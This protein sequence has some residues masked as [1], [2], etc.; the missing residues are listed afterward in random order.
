MFCAWCAELLRQCNCIHLFLF[1]MFFSHPGWSYDNTMRH[2]ITL[3]LFFWVLFV[4]A[5]PAPVIPVYDHV[6]PSCWTTLQSQKSDGWN[7]TGFS[8]HDCNFAAFRF[9]QDIG[10]H[11]LFEPYIFTSIRNGLNGS[12]N[13]SS[14]QDSSLNTANI[15]SVATSS[16]ISLP[17]RWSFRS[18][19][20]VIQMRQVYNDPAVPDKRNI[21]R[22]GPR[23]L[24][25]YDVDSFTDIAINGVQNLQKCYSS[26]K[27]P[28]WTIVGQK[29]AIG[30]FVWQTDSPMDEFTG[31]AVPLPPPSEARPDV[32]S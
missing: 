6:E 19:S 4:Q 21:L 11:N 2:L 30:V 23:E 15:S 32:T 25:T 22:K 5:S 13:S 26:Q 3:S 27:V 7:D 8:W 16:L 10:D 17:L 9:N 29:G 24:H 20:I 12:G 28:G 1:R 31:S 14:S 18:C